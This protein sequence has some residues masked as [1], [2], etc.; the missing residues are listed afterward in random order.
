MVLVADVLT[1]IDVDPRSTMRPCRTLSRLPLSGHRKIVPVG[2]VCG[3]NR[4][5]ALQ[6]NR[7]L[8]NGI[9]TDETSFI[10]LVAGYLNLR[11]LIFLR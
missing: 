4:A 7:D 2:P 1:R 3:H 8:C 5:H 6:K 9:K 11:E 10:D